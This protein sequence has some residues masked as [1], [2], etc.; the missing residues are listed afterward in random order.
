MT[1]PERMTISDD[2]VKPYKSYFSNCKKKVLEK[3]QRPK[4]NQYCETYSKPE[5]SIEKQYAYGMGTT[6]EIRVSSARHF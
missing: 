6:L 3:Y 1:S 2:Y 4:S 5:M